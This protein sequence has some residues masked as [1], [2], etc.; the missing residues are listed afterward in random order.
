M[1]ARFFSAMGFFGRGWRL[2]FAGGGLTVFVLLPATITALVTAGGSWA[3]YH[4]A[5]GWLDRHGAGHG[6]VAWLA[7]IAL[8]VV[9]L[10]V[11]YALYAASCVLAAAPFA[12]VLSERAEH[13]A[14]G[15]PVPPTPFGRAIALG[16]R[17]AGQALLGI[18]L[19]LA[20]AVPLFL[21]HWVAAPLAPFLW[22][23]SLVQTA[24]FFA[25]DAFNEPLHRRGASFRAKWRFIGAHL[26]ESLGFGLA[27]ALMMMIPLLSVVV[28]PVAVVGGTLLFL[29]LEGNK[30]TR[31]P[32]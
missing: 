24:L 10:M 4:W 15:T 30:P 12:G 11:A 26:A 29:E 28:A 19:Y 3:A 23:V 13:R 18:T 9:T 20:I 27:V 6:P 5:S 25:F 16:L 32:V 14:T 17:G 22:I 21:L 1:I 31:P 7:W 8:V 2:A